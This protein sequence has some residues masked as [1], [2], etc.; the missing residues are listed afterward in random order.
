LRTVTG[1]VV[2]GVGP[3]EPAEP[4]PKMRFTPMIALATIAVV[5][6]TAERAYDVIL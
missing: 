4:S 5:T 1:S 3:K 2:P 6:R